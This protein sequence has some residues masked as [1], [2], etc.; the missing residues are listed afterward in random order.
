MYA[1]NVTN[2][3]SREDDMEIDLL[4]DKR[5]EGISVG[6]QKFECKNCE[7]KGVEHKPFTLIPK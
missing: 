6:W 1:R 7:A 2:W 3:C 5:I 4:S